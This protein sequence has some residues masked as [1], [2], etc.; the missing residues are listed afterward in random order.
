[1]VPAHAAA[2][3]AG[4][5]QALNEAP[6]DPHP[7]HDLS[8][9]SALLGLLLH[10]SD[11]VLPELRA[12]LQPRDFFSVQHA[13]LYQA[14]LDLDE[15]GSKVE[16]SEVFHRLDRRAGHGLD[17]AELD[18]LKAFFQEPPTQQADVE[19]LL[20]R[21]LARSRSRELAHRLEL[22]LAEARRAPEDL[23]RH[24]E[25]ALAALLP[26]AR[27]LSERDESGLAAVA[28]RLK[29][30]QARRLSGWPMLDAQETWFA[31]GGLSLVLGRTGH[32]KTNLLLNLALHW[33]EQVP[34]ALVLVYSLEMTQEQLARRL[35]AMQASSGQSAGKGWGKHLLLLYTPRW[36]VERLAAD[37]LRR[38]AGRPRCSV[39]VDSLTALGAPPHARTH[40]RRDLELGEV[41][42]RLKE[43]AVALDGPVVATVPARRDN[44][45]AAGTP[46]RDLLAHGAEYTAPEVE[47]AIR[48]RRPRL[49]HLP[50][51][52]LDAHAD[53]VVA[54]LNFVADY[55]EELDPE[56]RQVFKARPVGGVELASLK[57]RDGGLHGAELQMDM[58]SGRIFEA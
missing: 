24:L 32:G 31:D 53:V 44:L 57:H 25:Q 10:R 18:R 36:D 9:E 43:L 51:S 52:G 5:G 3:P 16:A 12:R 11:E 17:E 49:E 26:L 35:L 14:A 38:A 56:H 15:S 33:Q 1:V 40:G 46:L 6:L 45:N 58:R 8:A 39:L 23:K 48:R 19:L 30:V 7:T 42:R 4:A 20:Q 54:L 37:A 55:Q 22:L 21:V 13:L 47:D 29:R 27:E 50:E 28:G 2:A 41:C 34:E